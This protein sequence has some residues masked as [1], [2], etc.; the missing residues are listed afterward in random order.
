MIDLFFTT[1][2]FVRNFHKGDPTWGKQAP[3]SFTFGFRRH[4]DCT[5][6]TSYVFPIAKSIGLFLLGSINTCV[7]SLTV[8]VSSSLSDFFSFSIVAILP[9]CCLSRTSYLV[10]CQKIVKKS[11]HGCLTEEVEK[12]LFYS[13]AQ[14]LCIKKLNY[15]DMIW[16]DIGRK[17]TANCCVLAKIFAQKLFHV[18]VNNHNLNKQEKP[19][20]ELVSS[21]RQAKSKRRSF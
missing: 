8:L 9:C 13:I 6:E 18:D 5:R 14:E 7:S 15:N 21:M 20:E 12:Y 3:Y 19:W 4:V 10:L 11:W 16:H 1:I 17:N 2:R